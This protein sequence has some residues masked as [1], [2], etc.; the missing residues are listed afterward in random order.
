MGLNEPPNK[1]KIEN[2]I[3]KMIFLLAAIIRASEGWFNEVYK[4]YS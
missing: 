2:Y 3:A 1:G 4:F